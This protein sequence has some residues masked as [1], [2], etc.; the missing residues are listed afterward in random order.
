MNHYYQIKFAGLTYYVEPFL[1]EGQLFAVIHR[2]D[3]LEQYGPDELPSLFDQEAH[4]ELAKMLGEVLRKEA[5][6]V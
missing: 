6:E 2:V 1:D 3:G 4:T 5:E